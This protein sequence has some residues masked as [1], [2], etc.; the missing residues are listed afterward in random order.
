L[1]KTDQINHQKPEQKEP[2]V[3]HQTLIS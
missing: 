2:L 1:I 3:Y